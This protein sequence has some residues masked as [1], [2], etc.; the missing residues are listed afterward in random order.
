MDAQK[1]FGELM[2]LGFILGREESE[3]GT[4]EKEQ[5]KKSQNSCCGAASSAVSWEHW[6]Q[7]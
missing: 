5:G 6:D 1:Q 7:V 3:V 4:P 2:R